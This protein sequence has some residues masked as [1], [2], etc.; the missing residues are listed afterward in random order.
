MNDLSQAQTDSIPAPEQPPSEDSA[1]YSRVDLCYDLPPGSSLEIVVHTRAPDGSLLE[2]RSL[3]LANPPL[4]AGTAAAHSGW[5]ERVRVFTRRLPLAKL[6]A[7]WQAWLFTAALL[8]YLLTRLVGLADFPIYFFTDEAVQTV[9]AADLVRDQFRGYSK[10]FLPT[11]FP[12]GNQYNL[13]VSV[14]LQ[15]IPYLIFGYSVW[16]TRAVSALMTLLAAWAVGRT[17]RDIYASQYA[18]AGVLLLAATP[19]W[20]LHSRTAF[21]T[22]LAASFFA[23]FLY[24]YMLYRCK[25]PRY[26]YAAVA[27]GALAFYTYS[28]MQMIMLVT[29]LLLLLVDA[30]YHWQQ[31]AVVLRGAGLALLLALPYARFLVN[32]PSENV[33]HLEIISSYWVQ[34]LTLPQKLARFGSEYLRALDPAY[35]FLANDTDLARH[36][37]GTSPHF[38]RLSLP[39][40]FLGIATAVRDFRF[41]P[42]RVM[43]AA[44]LAVPTG[45]ALV[46]VGITRLLAMA[47]PAVLLAALG[48]FTL[49]RWLE[50][51]RLKPTALSLVL[52]GLLAG[53]SLFQLDDALA[54][55]PTWFR[56][57]GLGGMQYGARQIFPAIQDAAAANLERRYLLSPSWTNGTEEVARFITGDDRLFDLGTIDSYMLDE[58]DDLERTTFV[59]IPEELR[60]ATASGKFS[61][62]T[63]ERVLLYPD[64][65]PG[66]FFMRMRYSDSFHRM[67][68]SEQQNRKMLQEA[69]VDWNGQPA[70]VRYSALDMGQIA[71]AL[72]GNPKSILRTLEANPLRLDIQPA[73][74]RAASAVRLRVGGNPTQV[75]L[76]L[77]LAGEDRPLIY[78]QAVEEASEPR[79]LRFEL[80]RQVQM[81]RLVV[82]VLSTGVGEPAHVHLWEVSVQP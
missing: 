52:F 76:H 46:G 31:R 48:L 78:R 4:P 55:G 68:E 9:R 74:P 8:L 43:L 11:F 5:G 67:L 3:R 28:P 72:D 69:T 59:M 82:E 2:E 22:A 19:A 25:S 38:L 47:I 12:N 40:I 24:F 62:M 13:S 50:R 37:M 15:V 56:D 54:N 70:L 79:F 77:Y 41:P 58:R 29:A 61:G 20:F 51:L 66:F 35:W 33:R 17:L 7:T 16:V 65:R 39:L 1:Q 26:L 30:R 60:M 6:A 32:H 80:G 44:L 18:W 71:D 73:Q 36:R 34:D 27:L 23:A 49:L 81:Q 53:S 45:A 64:S 75:T 14:Y 21:E 63:L 10:E 42:N 57:Y